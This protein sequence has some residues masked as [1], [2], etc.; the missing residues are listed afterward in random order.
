MGSGQPVHR[1]GHHLPLP[2]AIADDHGWA[3][4][5]ATDLFALLDGL[6]NNWLLQPEAFDLEVVGAQALDAYLV[7]LGGVLL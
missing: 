5:A 4:S 7:G 1:R 3:H 6:M 2:A